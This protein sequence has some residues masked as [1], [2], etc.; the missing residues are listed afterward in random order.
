MTGSY[1]TRRTLLIF[2]AALLALVFVP[3]AP[4]AHAAAGTGYWHTSGRQLLDSNGQPVRMTG[5]N[6]FGAET[7][8]YSPHGLW[9]RN[10]KD[11]LDQMK[12]LDYNT[13]RLP[14]TNQLFDS[15][16]APNSIDYAKNPDLQ[17]LDGLQILDKVID[18]AGQIGIKVVLDRHR[19]DAGGQSALWYTD[20]YPESR[21]ISDWEMLARHY[22]GNTT[23]IGA[24]LHNEPHSP[25][26]WGCGDQATDWRLAAERA[27]NA[28]L[29]VNSNWLIIVEGVNDHDGDNYW[30][31]GNLQGAAQYPVR[32]NV[33]NRL[34]Y[35]AH[36][37]ATSVYPQP[38]FDDPSFPDNLAAIWDKNWGYLYKNNV[39]PVLLGEF[40]TTLTDPRDQAWLR[41]LM[42]Y[43][44]TGTS[45]ISF[46]FWSW[47]PN[48]GDTGGILNGDWTSVNTAKQAYLD[49]YL[50][51]AFDGSGGDPGDGDPGGG[52]PGTPD[53][54]CTVAYKVQNSWQGGFTAQV[55]ITNSGSAALNGWTLG[56]A[57]PGDQKVSQGWSATWSQSGA[58][59]TAKSMDWNGGLAPG[60]SV[61]VGFQATGSSAAPAEFDLN[62]QP[63]EA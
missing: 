8:N 3:A 52:D 45:G 42:A 22:A 38:W 32:L 23:V 30:W 54:S 4:R 58:A 25:A 56:F 47:N 27:G 59:V 21:W 41:T 35:S 17:G 48:S 63:C 33:A 14:Y 36:D 60:A 39:A 29:A 9:T 11:M 62:D 18:Y 26:C 10:Y 51:G 15:G 20:A 53:V 31:G 24:D 2:L 46:T 49:P 43:L 40:G 61:T 55:T 28:I 57:F 13:L 1:G 44:G 50:L 7:S 5:I 16:S 19:P 37:Y 6:W 34:V 12:G